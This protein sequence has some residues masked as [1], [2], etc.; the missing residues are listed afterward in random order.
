MFDFLKVK[1]D[2]QKGRYYYKPTF[3]AKS[4][5]KDLMTR[6]GNF[7]AIYDEETGFWTKSKPRAIELI[8]KQVWEFTQKDSGQEAMNDPVHG[9][10]IITMADSA[11]RLVEQFDRFCKTMGDIWHPLDQKMLFSNSEIKRTDYAS[12]TLDYP[13]IEQPTPYYDAICDVLYLPDEREKWEWAVG[14][15]ITGDSVKIQKMFAF[16]GEPGT[17]KS[18]IISKIFAD[19]IFGGIDMGYAVKFE[20]NNLCGGNEFGTDFLEN[21]SVLVYDDDAEMGMITVRSTLNKIISHEQIRVNAKFKSPFMTRANCM[22]FV[23]SNDPIQLSP[24]SGMKRRL[25]DI[26]PTGN[27]LA[28]DVYDECMEHIPFEKSGIAWRCLQTYKKLGRHYYDH[29]IAEDMLVRTSPFHNYVVENVMELKDGVSLANAYDLYLRYAEMCKFK[30]EIPRYKFRDTLKLYFEKYEEQKFSGFRWDKIGKEKPV[31]VH[32]DIPNWLSF[33]C[34]RSDFD[35]AYCCQPAQYAND[36]GL[37]K[38]KWDKVKTVLGDLDTSKLHYVKMPEDIIC[39]DFDIKDK[40]GNKSLEKNLEAASKF[41]P[42]YAELSKSGSGIHL[43]YI[44]TGGDPKELSRI[45]DNNVEVKVFTGNAAL[46]RCLTKCNDIPIAEISSGLPLK[47]VK[48]GKKMVDWDGFTNEK[49]IRAMIIKNLKKEYHSATKP[50]IDYIDK[51]LTDAYNSGAS[52]DVRDLQN[53]ILAFA[54]NSTHQADYCVNRVSNMLFC[55]KDILDKEYEQENAPVDENAPIVIF[56]VEIAPSYDQYVEYCKKNDIP[57]NVKLLPKGVTKDTPAH[58]L[59]C[60][61]FLG[62]NKSIQKMLDPKPEEVAELFKYRLIGFNNRGYDNHMTW[63]ASQGYTMEELYS[64]N[65]KIIGEKDRKAK[66]GQAFNLSY[67]DILDFASSV[68]KMG[69]KKYEIQLGIHHMEWDRPWYEPIPD[70][71]LT[72][73]ADYCSND[74]LS[75][76]QVFYYLHDDYD[77]RLILAKLAGGIPNDTTN[78]LTIKLLTHGIDNPQ[79]Q[80]IYTDLSTIFPGYEFNPQGIPKERYSTEPGAKVPKDNRK[81]KS[82][83]MGEDPSEGGF[84]NCPKPGVYFNVGLFDIASMHPHSA[85]RL[86]IFGKTITKRYENLVEARVAIKHIKEIGDDAYKEALRRVDAIKEGSSEII[87]DILAGLSG[88]SLKSKCKSIANALKTAI[89]SVYGL[90][91]ASFDNKLRDP[92]NVDNIVA[93]YGALFMITLKHKLQEMGY[94]VVHIK[95]DSIKVANYDEKVKKFIFDFGKQYGFTFE[96]EATY[97]KMCII[98]DAQYIAYEVEADGEKLEKPFWT[99]TGAKFGGPMDKSGRKP[100]G[101]KYLFKSLFSH[102]EITFDDF[103]ETKSVDDAAIYLV[104]PSGAESFVGR[105]GSFVCVKPEYGAFLMRVKGDSRSFVTGTKGTDQN[106]LYWAEAESVREHPERLNLDYYRAQCDDAIDTINKLYPFDEFV[107]CDPTSLMF[108]PEGTP[109]EVEFTAMNPP[110]E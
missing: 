88:D 21:D 72:D 55:S 89:N 26:R 105:V 22:I 98:D 7:Y 3:I 68:N 23:G 66:F 2:Y 6:G 25:I 1:K 103:P 75:T 34:T 59:I 69:L 92:R 104:Y 67:T 28:S 24:N 46:R 83:Y 17:G 31:E 18:T 45:Y 91:S 61:K 85:I 44:Y 77:A 57:Y 12:K 58:F 13:L 102:E 86:K 35:E 11:N 5:I 50:S 94:T 37:P 73:W 109:E 63:A 16:Y 41:P 14:S 76:E 40:D 32:I 95:T 51:I 64:L 4:S 42:T 78:S 65:T 56:D 52:Y 62:E 27:L 33:D 43:H 48:G 110:V 93:K 38:I 90:T 29:Y 99:A 87:K 39:I 80:Y 71:R 96:H 54:M 82:I 15:M 19:Q 97:S 36:E 8:D 101:V 53:D 100:L 70:N 106:P 49:I 79:S 30:N 74:V 47:E 84:A 9:P 107:D 10:S 20:A 81:G 108:I 60:W